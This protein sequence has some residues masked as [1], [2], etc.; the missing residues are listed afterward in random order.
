MPP[1]TQP[2]REP[3]RPE[4]RPEIRPLSRNATRA[5]V[6]GSVL[7][8]LVAG[9]GGGYYLVRKAQE[10]AVQERI[11]TIRRLE[12]ERDSVGRA[13]EAVPPEVLRDALNDSSEA[14]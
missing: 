2:P 8:A 6:I 1:E 3:G 4:A 10:P 7:F 11:E 5:L 12:A 14:R 13:T 9:V